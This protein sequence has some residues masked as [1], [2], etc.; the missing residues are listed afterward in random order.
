[1]VDRLFP[2]REML[3]KL[4]AEKALAMDA[5]IHKPVPVVDRAAG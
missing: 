3:P 4:A 5:D 1:M 2:G